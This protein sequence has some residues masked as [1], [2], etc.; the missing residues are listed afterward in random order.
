MLVVGVVVGVPLVLAL[1]LVSLREPIRVALPAYAALIPFGSGLSTG[2]PLPFG[3]VSS[4][5][6][7]ALA[8]ALL[9]RLVTLRR[10]AGRLTADIPIWLGLLGLT[11]VSV[12]WSVAPSVTVNEFLILGSLVLLYV[13]LVLTG[14]SRTDLLRTEYALVIGGVVSSGYGLAQLLFLGGLP[15][16]QGVNPR[17]GE[18]LLGPDNQAAALL[19][20]TAIALGRLA[21]EEGRRRWIF[22][23]ATTTL[24][25]G[26]LLTGSRGGSLA[27]ILGLCTVVLATRRGRGAVIA[28]LVAGLLFL[29]VLLSV[30]PDGVG[31]RQTKANQSSSGRSDIWAVGLRA[32]ERYCLP[33]SGWGTFPQVYAAERATVPEARVLRRGVYFEPHSIWLQ[34]GVEAGFAGLL[35]LVTGLGLS[36][37]TA[38]RLPDRFRG[39]PLAGV[40]STIFAGFFLSNLQFKF[41]WMAL[42]YVQLCRQVAAAE[43]RS[44]AHP[45]AGSTGPEDDRTSTEL[46]PLTV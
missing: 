16:G 32:C 45:T 26:I 7:L 44:D 12:F 17:F 6:G 11:G 31:A 29:G 4:L 42:L 15:T 46:P 36:V 25:V 10:G 41:F 37:H 3:S 18:G 30:N 39:P 1:I 27:V 19:L 38:W 8:I 23:G 5:I 33:G 24:L 9:V 20:P 14:I 28:Y 40:L 43:A 21:I 35:L 22:A 2:L 13:L 34:M